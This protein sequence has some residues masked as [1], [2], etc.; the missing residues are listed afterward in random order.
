M[1]GKE[2]IS[3]ST[4]MRELLQSQLSG[5]NPNFGKQPSTELK[6]NK[7]I[8]GTGFHIVGNDEYG[9]FITLGPYKLTPPRKT[10]EECETMIANRDWDVIVGLVGATVEAYKQE[11]KWDADLQQQ[12]NIQTAN[13]NNPNETK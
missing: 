6:V 12:Q 9:Y 10:V 7:H 11:M 3:Q 1:T 2:T 13:S 4:P 8:E 5:E